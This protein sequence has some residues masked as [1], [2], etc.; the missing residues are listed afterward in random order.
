M[1]L[2]IALATN[3]PDR[4]RGMTNELVMIDEAIIGVAERFNDTFV[5]YD[6]QKVLEIMVKRDGMSYEEAMEFFDFNIVGAWVGP[7]TPAF[8]DVSL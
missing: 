8:V 7:K 2:F 5:V 6:K 4:I 3:K 1:S